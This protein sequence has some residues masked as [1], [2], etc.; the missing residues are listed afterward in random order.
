[1]ARRGR[2][3]RLG[4][5]MSPTN[6]QRLSLGVGL[7][8]LVVAGCALAESV[9]PEALA[10]V[11]GST[12]ASG[13]EGPPPRSFLSLIL[14]WAGAVVV[15]AL[16]GRVVFRE[17][18]TERD[19]LRMLRDS[20]GKVYPDF[21]PVQIT[22]W[23]TLAAPHIWAAWRTRAVTGLDDFTTARFR[24]ALDERFAHQIKTGE[25]HEARL[26]KVLKVH[27]LGM[28]PDGEGP[29]PK[30]LVLV[31][32][33]ETRA[34]D[35]LR[36]SDQRPIEGKPGERQVQHFW[37]LRHDGQRWLLDHI[38]LADGDRTDLAKK[39]PVPPLMDWQRD[40]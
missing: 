29:A 22:K 14:F 12:P 13:A 3:S 35:C 10:S 21:D 16:V 17:Q 1:M 34:V 38:E 4:G 30:D 18:L 6:K 8:V 40:I 23:V 20:I 27:M 25:R 37:T 33:I 7:L 15:M 2:L 26:G 24:E 9:P 31:L 19:T 28:Y 36:A 5:L 32:R 11:P 39:P